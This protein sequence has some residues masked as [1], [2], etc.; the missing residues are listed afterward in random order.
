M[1]TK[2]QIAFMKGRGTGKTKMASPKTKQEIAEAIY[3]HA[4]I[5]D[6]HLAD[7]A[8]ELKLKQNEVMSIMILGFAIRMPEG[9]YNRILL[10]Q[11]GLEILQA[12]ISQQYED[13]FNA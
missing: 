5:L 13:Q 10:K 12:T 6:E 2:Q 8:K 11:V 7:K 9:N 3:D 1:K 4:I